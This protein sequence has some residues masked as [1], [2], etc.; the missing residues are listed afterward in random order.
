MLLEENTCGSSAEECC[1]YDGHKQNL[2]PAD[3]RFYYF[4]VFIALS[5]DYSLNLLTQKEQ[6][7]CEKQI[8]KL[9]QRLLIEKCCK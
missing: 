4:N 5:Y 3:V 2:V 7:L 1:K 8:N 6:E 9:T